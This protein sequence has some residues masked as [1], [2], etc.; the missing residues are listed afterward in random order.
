[1]P[2]T[3]VGPLE[4]LGR[5]ACVTEAPG[6]TLLVRVAIGTVFI[7][8]GL[9]KFLFPQA[10]GVGR[11]EKIGIPA[12]DL[13]APFVAVVEV[14]CGALVLV[15]LLT[16]LAAVPLVLDMLVALASTKIPILLGHGYWGFAEPTVRDY[17]LW[18]ML[19]EARTDLSMLL[20][21]LFLLAV[22]AGA[23]SVDARIARK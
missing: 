23:R 7:S 15:G 22:G 8:E 11:F 19:H 17:G 20:C 14:G 3:P 5:F 18:S 6:A 10:L 4:R 2:A 9:Q 21:S 12:P 13:T 16:R 1:M